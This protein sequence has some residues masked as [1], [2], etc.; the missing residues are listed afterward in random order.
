[1]IGMTQWRRSSVRFGIWGFYPFSRPC[2]AV[3]DKRLIAAEQMDGLKPVEMG[4]VVVVNEGDGMGA[5]RVLTVHI[6][7][8]CTVN[9]E[10]IFAIPDVVRAVRFTLFLLIIRCL[11]GCWPWWQVLPCPTL[12]PS[13]GGGADDGRPELAEQSEKKGLLL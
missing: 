10:D 13:A 4:D 1:M 3:S 11:L 5:G 12:P 7:N 2:S 8:I 9:F 6:I